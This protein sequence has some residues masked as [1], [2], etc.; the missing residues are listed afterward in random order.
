MKTNKMMRIAS[1]LLV[2]VLLSTCAISGTFAK[3]VTTD[4]AQDNARVAKWGVTVSV[5]GDDAFK[6]VYDAK[7]GADYAST[8]TQTV[9]T[10]TDGDGKKLV[11]PGTDGT[12]TTVTITGK[13]EV[14]VNVK[15]EASLT[16]TGWEVDIT[17]DSTDNPV[18]YCPIVFTIDGATY[19]LQGSSAT[20]TY[21]SITELKNAVENK[22]NIDVNVAANTD[23]ASTYNTTVSWAWAYDNTTNSYIDDDKDSA[24]GDAA[25]AIIDFSYSVTITQID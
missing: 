19:G 24:L 5:T 4:S 18:E 10:A 6:T 14:A 2:A 15:K 16:L 3:Y 8:I 17:D 1:V 20:N 9:V 7:A 12:L 22:L 21:T 13:P 23:L 25:A 11:A